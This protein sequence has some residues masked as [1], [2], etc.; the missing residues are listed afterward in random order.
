VAILYRFAGF[1]E[2]A[3]SRYGFTTFAV[4]GNCPAAG[5]ESAVRFLLI[6]RILELD[7]GNSIK[8]VRALT[9]AEEY[10][11]DHF[12]RFPVM[13]G[14]MMLESLT[15]ASAWLIRKTDDFSHSLVV[16][17]EARNVKYAD[18]VAPGQLLTVH[19]RIQKCDGDLITLKAEGLANEKPAVNARLIMERYNLADRYPSRA[20]T[21]AFI[22]R[23][24]RGQFV[25]L[26]QPEMIPTEQK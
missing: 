5:H 3:G 25:K 4:I 10:L 14:V 18:F 9:L 16:L 7:E 15:Q 6:D 20:P 2:N 23:W 11:D 26:Y 21:D 17:R 1:G 8:A 24:L 22:I 12:P 19:A 13:P